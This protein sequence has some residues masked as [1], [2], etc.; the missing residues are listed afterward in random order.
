MRKSIIVVLIGIALALASAPIASAINRN[1]A[2]GKVALAAMEKAAI[3]KGWDLGSITVTMYGPQ[4]GS[5]QWVG[6]FVL[7]RYREADV[8]KCKG[9]VYVGPYGGIYNPTIHCKT[10]PPLQD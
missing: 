5:I 2:R 1:D 8:Q 3:G 4:G 6:H 7:M 9:V 10:L